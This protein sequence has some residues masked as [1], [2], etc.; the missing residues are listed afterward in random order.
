MKQTQD[1]KALTFDERVDKFKMGETK[2]ID[3]SVSP[4]IYSA[5][6]SDNYIL[7]RGV[8]YILKD[9]TNG[10]EVVVGDGE[11]TYSA[12]VK[13]DGGGGEAP[14]VSWDDITDK[15][16]TFAPTIGTTATTAKAGNYAPTWTEVTSKPTTFAPTIG[17]TASTAKAGNYT[18]STAEVS[19]ALKAKTQINALVS[20]TAD[21]ADLTEATAAIKSI[22]DALKA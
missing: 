16:T 8:T 11:S 10:D 14:T 6:K 17:T 21:Y 12:S 1:T 18:P 3:N 19:T 7:E 20:P 13:L 15:P 22:I 9:E 5:L 2:V 4:S